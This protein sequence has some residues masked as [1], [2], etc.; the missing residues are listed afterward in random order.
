MKILGTGAGREE[1]VCG[2]L[3][4]V[5][6]GG[7]GMVRTPGSEWGGRLK[8]RARRMGRTFRGKIQRQKSS[9]LMKP[10]PFL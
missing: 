6:R 3:E 9:R 7:G 5:R 4:K 1:R 10:S 2:G 8:H